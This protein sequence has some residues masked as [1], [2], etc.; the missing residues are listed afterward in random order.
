MH[1]LLPYPF[2]PDDFRSMCVSGRSGANLGRRVHSEMKAPC[3]DHPA[4]PC[5]KVENA[6][7]VVLLFVPETLEP[8]RISENGRYQLQSHQ[9][10]LHPCLESRPGSYEVLLCGCSL[11]SALICLPKCM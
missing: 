9:R 2:I 7:I 11:W 3:G 6:L 5:W 4:L 8:S 10:R 1:F